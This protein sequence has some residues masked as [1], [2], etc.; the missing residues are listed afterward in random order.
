MKKTL[1]LS[2]LTISLVFLFSSICNAQSSTIDKT[3]LIGIWQQCDSIGEP[4]KTG[5]G[6]TEYKI[7]TPESFTV[8]EVNKENGTF[9][10]VFFGRYTLENDTYT[11]TLTYTTPQMVGVKG[12][13]NLFNIAFKNNLWYIYGINNQ[14]KQVWKKMDKI[15]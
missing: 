12:T 11:E 2:A 9:V 10:A 8:L 4:V 15:D 1:I 14:Y 13:K 6:Y 7:I 5:P 3:K